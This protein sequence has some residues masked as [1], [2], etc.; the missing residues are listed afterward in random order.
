MTDSTIVTSIFVACP[1]LSLDRT[2]ALEDLQLGRVH[3]SSKS[4]I[5]GGGKGVNVARALACIGTPSRVAGMAAGRTGDAVIGLL[6][7]EAIHLT[8]T[9]PTGET[10]SCLTVLAQSHVTVF[11]ESG[12]VIDESAWE[13]FKRAVAD[14]L[15]DGEVFVCSGSWPPGAPPTA[16]AE[17]IST[18]AAR[19]CITICDT[20]R[21]QL[22]AALDASPDVVKPNLDE[23]LGLLAGAQH[24]RVDPAS[25][26]E[27]ARRAARALVQRGPHAVLVSAGAA[28]S[29]LATHDGTTD[30]P[31]PKVDVVNP[32]GAGDCLV[33]GLADALARAEQLDDAVRWGVAMAA[34]SCETF[35]AG[36]LERDRAEELYAMSSAI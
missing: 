25:G 6:A 15:T 18:A 22:R 17:L 16:A 29:V 30:H 12:P 14:E 4:D 32:V 34:A 5:R 19:G 13:Q 11:N 9:R 8:A 31:S 1:N 7:D 28:G 21:A 2:M 33:A 24:E 10:R 23:A 26:L 20:S 27:P 36:M 35:A 3:R